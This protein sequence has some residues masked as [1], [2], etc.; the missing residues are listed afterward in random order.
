MALITRNRFNIHLRVINEEI[1]NTIS[2]KVINECKARRW[3]PKYLNLRSS[4]FYEL[5]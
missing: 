2:I 5:R 3:R 4:G 1:A